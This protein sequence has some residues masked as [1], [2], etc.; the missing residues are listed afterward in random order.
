MT[1]TRV[2]PVGIKIDNEIKERSKRLADARQGTP[3]WLMREAI[4]Q[5]VEREERRQ[6]LRQD[7]TGLHV[8]KREADAW[9]EKLEAAEDIGTEPPECHD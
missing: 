5:Y 1:V 8:S 3:H 6:T 7:A 9:L 2:R 4:L